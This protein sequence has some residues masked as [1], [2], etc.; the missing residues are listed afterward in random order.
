M[1]D[2]NDGES[3]QLSWFNPKN[4]IYAAQRLVGSKLEA[5]ELAEENVQG[6]VFYTLLFGM[7]TGNSIGT[8]NT[9]AGRKRLHLGPV[10]VW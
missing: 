5:D 6:E 4:L 8:A 3:K 7:I 1:A 9:L 10:Y 2:S